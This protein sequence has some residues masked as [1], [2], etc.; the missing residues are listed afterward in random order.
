M[1]PPP[2]SVRGFNKVPRDFK[3]VVPGQGGS[4]FFGPLPSGGFA[5]T[6][7]GSSADS[8]A[9]LASSCSLRVSLSFRSL[10]SRIFC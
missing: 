1:P 4:V 2:F 6:A 3:K 9:F 7:M 5:V 10:A 8:L